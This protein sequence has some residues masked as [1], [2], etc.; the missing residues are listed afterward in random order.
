MLSDLVYLCDQFA[1]RAVEELPPEFRGRA[2]NSVKARLLQLAELIQ[3]EHSAELL[4]L[5]IMLEEAS[6]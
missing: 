2:K 5:Q 6:A 4:R 1:E 3:R